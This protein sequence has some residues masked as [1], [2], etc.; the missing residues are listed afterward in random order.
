MISKFGAVGDIFGSGKSRRKTFHQ[1]FAV[2]DPFDLE[3]SGER[4]VKEDTGVPKP[5]VNGQFAI[6][7]GPERGGRKTRSRTRAF[8]KKMCW[9][10]EDPAE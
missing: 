7:F 10:G 6:S 3:A 9:G 1:G 4:K 2:R 8:S 5:E